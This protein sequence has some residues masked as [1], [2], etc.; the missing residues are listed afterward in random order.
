MPFVDPALTE[1]LFEHA[2]GADGAVVR[3]DGHCQPLQAVYRREPMVRACAHALDSGDGRLLAA[4]AALDCVVVEETE[5]DRAAARS[6]ENVNTR[7]DLR[8]AAQ[9]IETDPE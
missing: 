2:D 8:A 5:L 7:A 3:V 1:T 6:F 4:L 9:R